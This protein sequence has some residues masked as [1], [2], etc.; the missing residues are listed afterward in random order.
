MRKLVRALVAGACVLGCLSA[1]SVAAEPADSSRSGAW[2]LQYGAGSSMHRFTVNYET[3]PLWSYPAGGTRIS[4][5]GELGVSYWRYDGHPENSHREAWQLSAIPMFQWW[6]TRQFYI[7]G[8]I[9]ATVFNTTRFAGKNIST[10]FQFGD[11]IG[12]GFKLN[13]SVRLNARYSHFSNAG[14]KRPNPGLDIFQV[15]VTVTW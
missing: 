15:G 7:E 1:T 2:S 13:D 11:H 4:L 10:A 9:G 5:V 3:A 8:G 12:V 14:I 6:F